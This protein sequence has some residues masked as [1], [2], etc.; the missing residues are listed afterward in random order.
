M[1]M[2]IGSQLLRAA[3]G[4]LGSNA[5]IGS[6]R[7]DVLDELHAEVGGGKKAATQAQLLRLDKSSSHLVV[8][9]AQT[10]E[11]DPLMYG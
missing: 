11:E 7:A 5:A 9:P 3:M 1:Q 4:V 6:A 10:S 2:R 8:C